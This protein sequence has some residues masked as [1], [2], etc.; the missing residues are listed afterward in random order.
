MFKSVGVDKTH[1]S[2]DAPNLKYNLYFCDNSLSPKC[3]LFFIDCFITW[4]WHLET[5][6]MHVPSCLYLQITISFLT[7]QLLCQQ[8]CSPDQNVTRMLTI[9]I[10]SWRKLQVSI[11]SPVNYALTWSCGY[12]AKR[13]IYVY[14]LYT[15][16]VGSQPTGAS[17]LVD[18]FPSIVMFSLQHKN[19]EQL[20]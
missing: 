16:I 10:N 15:A 13:V 18:V 20:P 9:F 19:W 3:Y 17:P 6:D 5:E 11:R 4:T 1:N 8:Q 7:E 2:L 12:L 14:E